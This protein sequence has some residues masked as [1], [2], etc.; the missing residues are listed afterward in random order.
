[1]ASASELGGRRFFA[2]SIGL[3]SLGFDNL[4]G[5]DPVVI[6]THVVEVPRLAKM[7]WVSRHR[8]FY[9]LHGRIQDAVTRRMAP[10]QLMV[11]T[12]TSKDKQ[13]Q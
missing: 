8:R 13:G 1:M 11:G 5:Y 4:I 12:A 2:M 10:D 9:S 3:T 6:S 7:D